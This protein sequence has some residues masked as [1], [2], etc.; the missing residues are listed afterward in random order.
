MAIKDDKVKT[1]NRN[2]YNKTLVGEDM[3]REILL[4]QIKIYDL[5]LACLTIP[6]FAHLCEYLPGEINKRLVTNQTEKSNE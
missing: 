4:D 6:A 5:T 1:I 3:I 2:P